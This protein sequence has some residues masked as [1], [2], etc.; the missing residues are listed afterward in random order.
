MIIDI[1]FGEWVPDQPDF[2][3]GVTVADG[4]V[5]RAGSYG[6]IAS[7]VATGV[8]LPSGVAIGAF[9]TDR[10][11]GTPVIYC[12]TSSDLFT[13]VGTVVTASGLALA[14]G[15]GSRWSFER[16]NNFIFA[17][18]VNRSLDVPQ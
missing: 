1:P 13:I 15:S 6:P 8:A 4:V 14:L 2:K 7:H 17:T 18:M 9:R 11:D 3:N 16:F 10:L 5:P 12:G